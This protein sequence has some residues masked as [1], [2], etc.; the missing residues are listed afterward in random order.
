MLLPDWVRLLLAGLATYRVARLIAIDEGPF[1]VFQRLR[2]VAGT[3]D[4]G[5]NGQPVSGLGRGLGCPYCVGLYVAVLAAAAVA[6]PSWLGDLVM[7][8]LGLA[9]AA[10]Y[11]QARS[12][13]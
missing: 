6:F 2:D 10:A 4:L 8:W 3:Y 13:R 7:L 9:G 11:L 5:E 12:V 1:S